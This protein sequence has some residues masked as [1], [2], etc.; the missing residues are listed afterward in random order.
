MNSPQ[1]VSTIQA[2]LVPAEY[3]FDLESDSEAAVGERGTLWHKLT[4][5]WREEVTPAS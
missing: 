4:E 3:G 5:M 2:Y 1:G